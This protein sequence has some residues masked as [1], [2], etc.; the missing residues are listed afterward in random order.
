M[1]WLTRG[2]AQQAGDCSFCKRIFAC[3]VPARG[4]LTSHIMMCGVHRAVRGSLFRSDELHYGDFFVLVL[5]AFELF[6]G[7]IEMDA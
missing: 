1:E 6:V 7:D 3:T 4:K 5:A 2:E